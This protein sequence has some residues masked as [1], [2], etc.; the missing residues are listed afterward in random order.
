MGL[1][2]PVSQSSGPVHTRDVALRLRRGAQAPFIYKHHT[3]PPR[4]PLTPDQLFETSATLR[5][6]G[7]ALSAVNINNAT[8]SALHRPAQ[9]LMALACSAPNARTTL[10]TAHARKDE[11]DRQVEA[12]VQYRLCNLDTH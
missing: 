8:R 1:A 6:P 3:Q 11:T 4:P 2:D 5:E 10:P 12:R 7:A 9:P